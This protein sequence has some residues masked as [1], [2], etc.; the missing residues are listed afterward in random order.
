MIN[1]FTFKPGPKEWMKIEEQDKHAHFVN[2]DKNSESMTYFDGSHIWDAIYNENC[3]SLNLNNRCKEDRI[4]YKLI[5]GVHSNINMHISHFDFDLD[6]KQLPPNYDRYYE[7][8]GSHEERLKNMMFTYSFALQ[9]INH[10]SDKVDG[11]DLILDNSENEEECNDYVKGLLVELVHKSLKTCREPFKE[12]N[13]LE[14]M[15]EK[16]FI[17]TIKP[18]FY[19]IT[20]ILD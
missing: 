2:L 4:L 6:G 17:D 13:M 8:V 20:R 9:A 3:M 5:S 19:N 11:F 7:R 12:R 1:S 14:M 10:L 18:I 15:N 16:Q